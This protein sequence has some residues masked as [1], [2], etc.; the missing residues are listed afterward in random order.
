MASGTH[1]ISA[2]LSPMKD[3]SLAAALLKVSE[4]KGLQDDFH[5]ENVVY[6]G[7]EEPFNGWTN[8]IPTPR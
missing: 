2:H 7:N 1:V 4:R 3:R 6:C 5:V 8:V